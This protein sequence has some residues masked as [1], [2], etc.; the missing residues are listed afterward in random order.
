MKLLFATDLH[1]AKWKYILMLEL[2]KKHQVDVVIN[3]GDMLPIGGINLFNQDL[4]IKEFLDDYFLKFEKKKI[5]YMCYLGNDDLRIFDEIFEDIY[6]K[7][8]FII[9][10]AQRKYKLR[11]FEFIGMNWVVDYP[12]ALKDRCRKDTPDYVFQKQFGK[13]VLSTPNGWQKIEDWF[14]YAATIPTFEEELNNL[15]RPEAME[16]AIYIIHMPPAN[17]GL[18]ICSDGQK[19]GSK[20]LYNFIKENQPKLTLHGHIHESPEVSGKWYSTVGKTISI[21]PGQSSHHED[22]LSYV[23]IDLNTMKFER[24][25]HIKDF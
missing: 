7:Y 14:S 1:G 3:G 16:N 25:I 12:F 11:N 6:N 8:N 24:L 10:L 15:V 17:I 19:A 21:Q 23:I 4:F 20:A 22:Y 5:Y 9:P 13:A 18:D 2:I